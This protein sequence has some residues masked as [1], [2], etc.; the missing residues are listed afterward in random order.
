MKPSEYSSSSKKYIDKRL[1]YDSNL[2]WLPSSP[3]SHIRL[4]SSSAVVAARFPSHPLNWMTKD[5]YDPCGA[6][7]ASLRYDIK[8][9]KKAL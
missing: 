6:I 8:M 4:I 9:T 2:G 7:F 1:A 3:I 5:V